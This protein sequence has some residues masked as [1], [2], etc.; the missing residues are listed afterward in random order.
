M[1]VHFSL[2]LKNPVSVTLTLAFE[3]YIMYSF[4][5]GKHLGQSQEK[6]MPSGRVMSPLHGKS[7]GLCCYL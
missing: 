5:Y 6:E 1:F 2:I 7:T 4:R 3:E